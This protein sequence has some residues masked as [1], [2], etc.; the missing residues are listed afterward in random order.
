ML[1]MDEGVIVQEGDP[2]AMFDRPEHPR[3]R[4]FLSRIL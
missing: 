3:L 2:R 4:K 1:F